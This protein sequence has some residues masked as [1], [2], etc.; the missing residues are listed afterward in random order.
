MPAPANLV[1]ETTTGTGTGNLTVASESGKQSFNDAFG[2]GG[3][4]TFDYFIS[5]Q[6]AN[7]WEHG[8]GHLSDAT[9][10]VRDT[11][12][13][14]S[15]ADAAVNFSAGTKD[16]T[17]D[18]PADKIVRT[19]GTQTLT[20][21][22]L[23]SPTIN[24]PALGA[25]SVDAITEIASGLK[26]GSDATLVTG[27]AGGGG[28]Y[29]M[30]NGDGDLVAAAQGGDIASASPLVIDTDGTY[31]DV[32]GTTGF[33]AMTVA[34]GRLFMLQFD[35]ALTITHGASIDLPTEANYTTA[36]GDRMI[37]YSTATD[38]VQV[39][40][41]SKAGETPAYLGIAQEFTRAQNFDATTLT[42]GA[43]IDWNLEQNQVAILTLG[44]NRSLNAASNLKA[45]GTY[46]LIINQDGTGSRTLSWHSIYKF[47]GGT[48]PTLSTG[49]NAIDVVS[50]VS[51]GTNLLGVAQLNFS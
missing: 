3:T 27:T 35:G 37:C 47:P 49:A 33:S 2:T 21:K 6:S 10:L 32:T 45:G 38:T 13:D 31:F 48:D 8:T 7:E 39:I 19:D 16:V 17:N 1:H 43:T 24:S 30:F 50:F 11:V 20:N 29:P 25:D 23:T 9:T 14:S 42:D 28:M 36:A 4:D 22:T 40:A 18:V 5:H 15:N 26:S 44:G 46:I 41:I 12:I 34:A 51:D